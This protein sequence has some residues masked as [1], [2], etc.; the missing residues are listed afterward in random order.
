MRCEYHDLRDRY[1]KLARDWKALG[2]GYQKAID[3]ARYYNRL[4][5]AR[6]KEG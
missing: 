2:F 3:T 6:L 5:V 1:L 4:I